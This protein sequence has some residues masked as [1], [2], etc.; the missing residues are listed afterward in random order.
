MGTRAPHPSAFHPT[1][2]LRKRG[3]KMALTGKQQTSIKQR[4][5]NISIKKSSDGGSG[6]QS[7]RMALA[8]LGG[9]GGSISGA[10]REVATDPQGVIQHRQREKRDLQDLN[11]RFATYIEKIRFYEVENKR[12]KNENESLRN[13]LISLEKK[14]KELYENELANARMVIDQTTKAKAAVELKV[15]GLETDLKDFRNKYELEL[16]AH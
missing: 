2:E 6:G 7:L 10:V 13:A 9:G 5:T 3:F 1:A 4:E 14:M 15:A 11:D 8:S 12:L 16:K